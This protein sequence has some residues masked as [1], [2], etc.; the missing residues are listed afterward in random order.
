MKVKINYNKI[1]SYLPKAF[2]WVLT[3]AFMSGCKKYLPQERETVGA[4][5]Q[6]T[7]TTFEPVLGRTT[8]FNG[9]FFKGSTTYPS[10]FKI[11]NP[12]R[13]NGDAAP[14][15]E[16]VLPV[17]FWKKAYNGNETSIAAIEEKREK[18]FR[19]IFEISP[20]TGDFTLWAEARTSFMRPQ[21]DSGYLFDVEVSNSGGRRY[22]RNLKLMPMRERPYEPSNYNPISGQPISRAFHP[23]VIFLHMT[24]MF[25]SARWK[26][27]HLSRAIL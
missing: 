22:Y 3:V 21:P 20:H 9:N 18:Q 13:R 2:I 14:E 5:S 24:L 8:Y 7:V 1:N 16:N 27:R 23:T 26:R 15:L 12:R 17:T 4:D 19:P 6:F 10:D 25:I 11:V